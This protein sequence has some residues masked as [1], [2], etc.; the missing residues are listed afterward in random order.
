MSTTT[1]RTL[2]G[3]EYTR[4]NV[5]ISFILYFGV[6]KLAVIVKIS[7][8]VD[9][10]QKRLLIKLSLSPSVLERH[11]LVLVNDDCKVRKRGLTTNN[12]LVPKKIR[13]K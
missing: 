3:R 4:H 7:C 2:I 12:T 5:K 11:E 8:V 9:N 13:I 6:I 1:T 10:M